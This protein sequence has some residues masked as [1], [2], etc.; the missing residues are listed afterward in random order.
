M[1]GAP[2]EPRQWSVEHDGLR[3]GAL[4]WGGDGPPLLLLHPNGFC[5]GMFE[6]LARRLRDTYRVVAVDLRGHGASDAPT[7]VEQ[8]S[9]RDVARDTLAVVDALGFDDVD[10]VGES[11]GGS[12]AILLDELRP[13]L[14]R[15]AVL[16]EA[17]A[18]PEL[19]PGS[20]NVRA[21]GAR[22]RRVVWPSRDAVLESYGRRPP[23]DAMEHAALAGYVRCGFRDRTDGHVEL[24]CPPEVEAWFFEGGPGGDGPQAT[25]A[26]LRALQARATVVRG[27]D[28]DLPRFLLEAQAEVLGTEVLVVPGGH[29]FLQQSTDLA[30][31]LV[32]THLPV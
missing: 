18:F 2:D 16:C 26:H 22:R 25:F 4:D 5:A 11:L 12:A 28:T 30:E 29:F 7:R 21:D 15:R 17:I 32:R 27:E 10:V 31:E 9:Y 20:G 3:I 13:G 8:C 6:P 14:V 24:A 23:L 19:G 1:T